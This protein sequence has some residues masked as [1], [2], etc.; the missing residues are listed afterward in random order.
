MSLYDARHS[1]RTV[2]VVAAVAGAVVQLPAAA[3]AA[4]VRSRAAGASADTLEI[5]DVSRRRPTGLV[6][7][8]PEPEDL[9]RPL[10]VLDPRLED[11]ILS[12]AQRSPLWRQALLAIREQRFPV[13]V[14]SIVQVEE[15]LPA[16]R[17]LRF[18]GAAAVWLFTDPG[19]RAVAAAVT[20]NIPKLVIRNRILEGDGASLQR[21]LELHLAHEMYGHLV[22]VVESGDP[23]HPCG[24]DPARDAPPAAQVESCVMQRESRL[25]EDLGYH[26]RE[27][28]LW[29][30]WGEP[31][32]PA[33]R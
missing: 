21:M 20:V 3:D 11:R 13:L 19:G 27:S 28:Y 10:M 2:A 17:R 22:P 33:D 18:D 7:S 12:M 30:Y 1:P 5:T 25:L 8:F 16:L 6:V 4:D 29:D 15:R 24:T 26:P 32:V 9:D 31:V 23:N 14:G